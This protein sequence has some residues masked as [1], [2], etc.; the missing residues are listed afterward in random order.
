MLW[1]I[2]KIF[3]VVW[4]LELVLRFGGSAIQIVLVVSFAALLLRLAIP[5]TYFNAGRLRVSA[6]TGRLN[7]T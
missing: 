6:K 5:G 1:T 7:S 4:M 3:M 2:F